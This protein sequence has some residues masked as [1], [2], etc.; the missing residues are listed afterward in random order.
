MIIN[1]ADEYQKA[2]ASFMSE[3]ENRVR[4]WLSWNRSLLTIAIVL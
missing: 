2:K 1:C 3:Y 4:R